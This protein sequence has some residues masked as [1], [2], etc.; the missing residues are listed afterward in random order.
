MG[1]PKEFNW[2]GLH[3]GQI[4]ISEDIRVFQQHDATV[5][6]C[7]LV[8]IIDKIGW[9]P[10]SEFTWIKAVQLPM[11]ELAHF[12]WNEVESDIIYNGVSKGWAKK[13]RLGRTEMTMDFPPIRRGRKKPKVLT[14]RGDVEP[15]KSCLPW[16]L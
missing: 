6:V 12:R 4:S 10:G 11:T 16:S 14:P 8:V 5:N 3:I 2:A 15:P 13:G 7:R 1:A 9:I